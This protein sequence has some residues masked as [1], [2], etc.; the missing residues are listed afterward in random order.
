MCGSSANTVRAH[1]ERAQATCEM[2]LRSVSSFMGYYS[3]AFFR[4]FNSCIFG[5]FLPTVS[6]EEVKARKAAPFPE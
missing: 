5:S 4:S 1:A 6:L 3:F 2:E